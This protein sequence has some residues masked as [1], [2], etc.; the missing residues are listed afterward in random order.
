MFMAPRI[1]PFASCLRAL[2]QAAYPASFSASE[3]VRPDRPIDNG[4]K[5]LVVNQIVLNKTIGES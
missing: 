3:P 5:N 1:L 2:A 4:S